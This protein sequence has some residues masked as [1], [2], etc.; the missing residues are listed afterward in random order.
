MAAPSEC[1]QSAAIEYD[2]N[3]V[4]VSHPRQSWHTPQTSKGHNFEGFSGETSGPGLS[5]KAGTVRAQYAPGACPVWILSHSAKM[6][7]VGVVSMGPPPAPIQVLQPGHF[8]YVHSALFLQL[9]RDV[10]LRS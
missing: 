3:V 2:V 7:R 4:R 9:W 1:G 10:A 5:P 6:E 8:R